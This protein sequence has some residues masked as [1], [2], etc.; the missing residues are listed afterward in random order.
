MPDALGNGRNRISGVIILGTVIR[1]LLDGGESKKL[2]SR[3][4]Y[5]IENKRFFTIEINR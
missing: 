2:L 1:D 4:F 3:Q 5:L